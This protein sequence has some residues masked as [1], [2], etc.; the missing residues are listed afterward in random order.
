MT[1]LTLVASGCAPRQPFYFFED[2]DLSHYVGAIQKI[3]YPD[4]VHQPLDEAAGTIEPLTLS[5]ATFDQVWELSLEDALRTV[6]R[7]KKQRE[8]FESLRGIGWH[9]DLDA[10]REVRAD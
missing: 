1:S 9:G 10:M 4:T 7:I 6:L 5:N 3:E 8:A 2:G